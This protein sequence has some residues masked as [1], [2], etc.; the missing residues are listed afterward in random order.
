LQNGDET[1]NLDATST[2]LMDIPSTSS[3]NILDINFF[4]TISL[5]GT[6]MNKG[7]T[8]VTSTESSFVSNT[9]LITNMIDQIGK[10]SLT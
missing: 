2:E 3:T 10:E 1:K 8:E 4:D 6:I 5:N 9:E 7:S